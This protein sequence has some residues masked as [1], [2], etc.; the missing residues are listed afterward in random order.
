MIEWD[1]NWI[2][3]TNRYC[4]ISSFVLRVSTFR[5]WFQYEGRQVPLP[6]K[7]G[8]IIEYHWIK[9]NRSGDP[10]Q[11]ASC[12]LHPAC[13][14]VRAS[15]FSVLPLYPND[16]GWEIT[17]DTYH[18][19]CSRSCGPIHNTWSC[20]YHPINSFAL[21]FLYWLSFVT[22][23]GCMM[24]ILCWICWAII[25]PL[26]GRNSKTTIIKQDKV[27]QHNMP[28]FAVLVALSIIHHRF[29]RIYHHPSL[30]HHC[31]S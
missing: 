21:C 2:Q 4:C 6:R 24:L 22:G 16:H 11:T 28:T 14:N 18:E 26:Q 31:L 25:K 27:C 8:L 19:C 9:S 23:R 17:D 12:W 30:T 13:R 5:L 7:L 15:R 29:V 20:V 1:M 10:N 3:L